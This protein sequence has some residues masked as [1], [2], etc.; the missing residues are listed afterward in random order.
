MPDTARKQ[1]GFSY[2]REAAI[3]VEGHVWE[4][5][6][7][8]AADTASG[9]AREL[10]IEYFRNNRDKDRAADPF[11][12]GRIVVVLKASAVWESPTTAATDDR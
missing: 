5:G 10:H 11:T 12:S 6:T 3:G 1:H 7:A 8:V 9:Q 4:L 2:W